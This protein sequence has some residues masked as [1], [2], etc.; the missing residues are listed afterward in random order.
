MQHQKDQY[1]KHVLRSKLPQTSEVELHLFEY[2]NLACSFC[3]QDHDSKE[4]MNTIVEK[5]QQVIDF[6]QGCELDSHTVNIMGGEIFND[7]IPSEVFSQYLEFCKRITDYCQNTN[8]KVQFNFVS[9]LIF[10]K[11]IGNVLHLLEAVK[12]SKISTSYD[13][14]GRGLDINRM[15]TFKW[16][17]KLL[18]EHIGVVGFVLSRPSIRKFIDDKDK[19]FKQ[20]L[21]PNF[22]IYFDWYVP[23]GSADKMLPS[24]Q[25]MLDAFLFAAEHY[26]NIAPVSD[27]IENES[28]EM[29]CFSLYKTTILPSGREV[30]CRY[31]EYEQ[32]QFETPIDYSTNVD[33]IS[34]HLERNEC[35]SCQ[36]FERCQFRCF[37]QSDWKALERLPRCMFKYF[38]EQVIENDGKPKS[39]C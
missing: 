38:F 33:I 13:F 3:G 4:G 26:P 39:L 10:T 24:E 36:W 19:F 21:Y 20:E 30:T 7:D 29:T 11:N 27:L 16:N 23:E 12:G 9:N 2:C 8:Q 25:E 18:K 6:M 37:V 34:A 35:M 31:L 1:L 32:K 28:N 22:P 15:M 5:A 17:I 14:A